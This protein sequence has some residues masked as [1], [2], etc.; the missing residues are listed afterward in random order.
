MLFAHEEFDHE[1]VMFGR[2]KNRGLNAIVAIRN[3]NRGPAIGGCRMMDYPDEASA[4]TVVL[5]LSKGM[6]YKCA[7]GDIP[8]GGG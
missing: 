4:F 3:R 6:T 8:F 1:T 5:R 7:I 2:D